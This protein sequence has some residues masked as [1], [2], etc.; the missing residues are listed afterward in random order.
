MGS[1]GYICKGIALGIVGVLY[2][3]WPW[4]S[5]SPASAFTASCGLGSR[6]LGPR[7]TVLPQRSGCLPPILRRQRVWRGRGPSAQFVVE[8]GGGEPPRMAWWFLDQLDLVAVR[9]LE[10]CE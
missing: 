2:C 6:R 7:W 9:S 8:V 1:V 4:P 3:W 5:G 10:Y